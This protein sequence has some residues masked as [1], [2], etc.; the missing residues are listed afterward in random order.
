MYQVAIFIGIYSYLIFFLGILGL[1][2]KNILIFSSIAYLLI[3]LFYYFRKISLRKIYYDK[4]SFDKFSKFILSLLFIQVL[5]NLIGVFGPE[6]AFDSLWYHLTLPKLYLQN[7]SIFHIPG[8]L[9]YYSDMPKGIEML[10]ISA[11]TFNGE[12]LAKLISFSFSILILF[13]LYKLSNN[14]LSKKYSLLVCLVFY[15][16]LV[17]GWQSTTAYVDL[18]RTFFELMAFTQFYFWIKTK[19]DKFLLFSALMTGFSIAVKIGAFNS[20]FLFLFLILTISYARKEEL[21]KIFL[22]LFKYILISVLVPLPWFIFSYVNTGNPFYPLFSQI[23]IN[24]KSNIA[25]LINVFLYASDPINPIY[26]ITIPLV[27]YF[28]KKFN[29]IDKILVWYCLLSLSFWYINSQIG[30]T[31]FLMPYLP[32]FS[33]LVIITFT[34]IK[35]KSLKNYLILV[36]IFISIISISYRSMANRKYV[37]VILGKET[38]SE[39]LVNNLNYSFGDFYDTDN[40]FKDNIKPQDKVLLFGFHNLYYADFPFTDS[41]WVKSGDRFNYVAV[42]NGVIPQ[43]FSNWNKIY[44]NSK[45]KVSLYSKENKLWVY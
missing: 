14:F 6:I 12:I 3:V 10:F 8:N 28:F 9:L 7:H 37:P 45:T 27:I 5:V 20:L 21:Y 19:K 29:F 30:G 31:R 38:K 4:F 42:Q 25:G 24:F 16:N 36:L 35:S 13:A 1:L 41:S 26:L 40:Y 44:Y 39:F 2:Y 17:V 33:I 15:S 32:V 34:Y 23:S 43:R 22:N 11:L 18:G